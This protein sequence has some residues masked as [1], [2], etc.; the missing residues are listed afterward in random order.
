MLH[1]CVCSV[2]LYAQLMFMI[3]W[4][5]CSVG[6]YDRSVF[7]LRQFVYNVVSLV[8]DLSAPVLWCSRLTYEGCPT[9]SKTLFIKDLYHVTI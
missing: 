1:Q 2:G 5:L 7:M 8:G 6:L 4:I 3:S 9:K